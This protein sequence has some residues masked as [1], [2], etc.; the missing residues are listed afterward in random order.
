MGS[1]HLEIRLLSLPVAVALAS[2]HDPDPDPSRML[3]IVRLE[4]EHGAVG[5]GECAALN[6]PG[7]T[8]EW[9]AGAY[10]ILR[11]A[12]ELDERGG[13][14]TLV[15]VAPMAMAALEM[16]EYDLRLTEQG[17]SL[18]QFLDVDRASV[19]AGAV[20]PAGTVEQAVES[21][22]YLDRLG[23]HRI[24][25]KVAPSDRS[26]FRPAVLV[27]AVACEIPGIAIQLDANGSFDTAS[28]GEIAELDGV[29][30][31]QPF[32]ARDTHLAAEAVAAGVGVLA[33]EGA[34][35]MTAVERLVELG[36]CTGIVVKPPRLGGIAAAFD[37][38][39]WCAQHGV[40]AAAGGMLESSLGRHALAVTAAH[41]AC[42]I[43]GDLSPASRWLA[44]DP[45]PDLVMDTA[46]MIA[47]PSGP[48]VAPQPDLEILT[49]HTVDVALREIIVD[50]R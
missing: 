13:A 2:T 44:G 10:E 42:T 28:A 40:P 33:D 5:W 11:S 31:E 24:K 9:A 29:V 6:R 22:G 8:D 35:S 14:A 27:D 1:L 50:D 4:N 36:A 39:G 49:E 37:M 41:D 43:V 3:T 16:A 12:P 17:V 47:V 38:L 25:F 46:G 18:A 45:W 23:Y 7:Y 32:P 15:R 30:V 21:A 34:V 48:G 19:P 26:G 20:V